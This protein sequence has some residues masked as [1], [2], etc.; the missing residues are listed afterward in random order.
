M[1]HIVANKWVFGTLVLLIGLILGWILKPGDGQGQ[2]THDHATDAQVWTCSMHPQIRQDSPGQCPICG[3]DLVPVQQMTTADLAPGQLQLSEAAM[4]LANIQT[5][6]VTRG[7][8]GKTIF[9]QGIV[10]PDERQYAI[11][12]AH[13]AGRIEKLF[14]D[15]TGQ[16]IRKGQK[17]ATLYSPGLV[18]AQR[19]LFETAKFRETNP[20]YFEAAVQKLK[21]WELSQ[22]QIDAILASGKPT[23]YFDIYAHRSGTILSRKV[24]EGA[25]V[26][27]GE[28]LFVIAD[29][30]RMW[31]E[32]D[33]Y[34]SDLSWIQTGVPVQ[35]EVPSVPGRSFT[36]V[37]TFIDPV[38]DP[39]SRTAKIRIDVPNHEGLLKPE[40][41]AKGIINGS[42][43]ESEALLVPATAILWTGKRA[44]VYVRV[45]GTELP[46]F[47]FREIGI[48]AEV[49]D[50]YQVID[51]LQE[52][53]EVVVN[54]VFKIDASAQ[55]QGRTS[56]MNRPTEPAG[57]KKIPVS[58]NYTMIETQR[59]QG[60]DQVSFPVISP[61]ND[62]YETNQGFAQQLKAL[63]QEY[64]KVKEALVKDDAMAAGIQSTAFLAVLKKVDPSAISGKAGAEWQEDAQILSEIAL[65]L[66][67]HPPL[68]QSR[69]AFLPL[70]DQL[71]H[72]LKKFQV[73][74]GA[75][76]MFCPMA[77]AN[78][79]A[80]WLSDSMEIENPY[81]GSQMLTCGNVEEELN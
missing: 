33:A 81:F 14:V 30:S 3:M 11:V 15:F 75:Y 68:D 42:V 36:S 32:F 51:G 2:S 41:F 4:Q 5:R 66:A 28:E 44:V 9:L 73:K 50:Q 39:Q 26:M 58:E 56:M 76:R 53:E 18:T 48:G 60:L 69:R 22:S 79:G 35:Y 8:T 62:L 23:F 29:L 37:V 19:E 27:E 31:I 63:Y 70:S 45:P 16:K 65:Y 40:M 61:A 43:S 71:Y 54:G 77:D 21:L 7:N 34:E 24:T 59:A 47:E 46:T 64:L 25:H 10:R 38:V 1:K 52:G 17:M 72:S 13:F 74:T 12:T 55:L 67:G 49:G 78:R 20:A 57:E 80:Y 6:K